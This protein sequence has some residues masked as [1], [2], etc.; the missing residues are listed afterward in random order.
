[1]LLDEQP[2]DVEAIE[3]T[4]YDCWF[5][6]EDEDYSFDFLT[7]KLANDPSAVAHECESVFQSWMRTLKIDS[8]PAG[9]YIDVFNARLAQCTDPWLALESCQKDAVARVLDA[10]Y[11]VYVSDTFV[12]VYPRSA[13]TKLAVAVD[14]LWAV[15]DTCLTTSPMPSNLPLASARMALGAEVANEP[16]RHN[17]VLATQL[18]AAPPSALRVC[19]H[20]HTLGRHHRHHTLD[21][22]TLESAPTWAL[23]F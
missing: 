12:E 14:A 4:H 11:D 23:S 20:R 6:P 19:V 15:W 22:L 16:T 3:L 21:R 8:P 13:A 1:M 7:D 9:H 2:Q 10:G 17:N 18:V 5:V